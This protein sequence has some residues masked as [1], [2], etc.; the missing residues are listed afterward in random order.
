[1]T[2]HPCSDGVRSHVSPDSAKPAAR[3]IAP[4][5]GTVRLL[6]ACRMLLPQA[7]SEEGR[8]ST[9]SLPSSI[10]AIGETRHP[11][12]DP[13]SQGAALLAMGKQNTHPS[14]NLLNG[15]AHRSRRGGQRQRCISSPAGTWPR[16]G[17]P[18]VF[19]VDACAMRFLSWVRCASTFRCIATSRYRSP[20]DTHSLVPRLQ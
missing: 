2:F 16:G 7:R 9:P 14:I 17:C 11:S 1:M 19:H 13:A 8:I 6:G 10:I 5:P 15:N 4:V 18:P 12:I 20:V 3:R